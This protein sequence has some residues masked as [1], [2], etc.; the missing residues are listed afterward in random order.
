MT[1]FYNGI[2]LGI[3]SLHDFAS[4]SVYDN[5]Q[6]DYLYSKITINA[7]AIVNGQ[8]EIREIAG[9]PTSYSTSPDATDS[10]AGSIVFNSPDGIEVSLE[11]A[12]SN[13]VNIEKHN[14]GFQLPGGPGGLTLKGI[15]AESNN[16]PRTFRLVKGPTASINSAITLRQFL[17]VPRRQLFVFSGDGDPAKDV[18]L[19]HSPGFGFHTD[20]KNG[21][22]PKIF[23]IN[24]SIGDA[25]TFIINFQIVTY[26]NEQLPNEL[27]ELYGNDSYMRKTRKYL[28]SNRFSMVHAINDDSYLTV[29]VEGTA[30]F[31]TDLMYLD[32]FSPD[33]GRVNLFLPVPFGCV[34]S[35]IQVAGLPD[36]T[37]VRYSFVDSQQMVHFPIG[38][39]LRASKISCVH[40][41]AVAIETDLFTD[42]ISAALNSYERMTGIRAN[43][44]IGQG[45]VHFDAEEKVTNLENK[46]EE[47]NAKID[48]LKGGG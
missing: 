28:L 16:N 31:R 48:A 24:K 36:G 27:G 41:Q 11:Q 13:N 45:G 20:C 34:R 21:P 2:E 40:R 6:T 5:S 14:K 10:L 3:L 12:S 1:V 26:V 44:K 9:S 42:G 38:A 30:H 23:S 17:S 25:E 18:V 29:Q 39:E 35:N 33:E 43:R 37:G 15:Y 7:T 46:I 4:E 32:N 8:T 47:L 22:I 19:L